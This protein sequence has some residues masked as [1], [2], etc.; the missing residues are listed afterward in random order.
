MVERW[1][2]FTALS[3]DGSSMVY[4]DTVG[5]ASGWQLWIRER[6][7]PD[8]RRLP[9]TTNAGDVVFSPDGQSIVF[10]VGPDLYR[11]HIQGGVSELLFQGT[12]GYSVAMGWMADGSILVEHGAGYL[13]R[14][15]PDPASPVDTVIRFQ[16]EDPDWLYGL[17]GGEAALVVM[18]R[19]ALCTRGNYVG[20]LDL[21]AGSLKPLLDGVLRAWYVDTG[22]VV[23]VNR[24]GSVFATPFDLNGLDFSGEHIPLFEGVQASYFHAD[25]ALGKDGTVLFVKG[26]SAPIQRGEVVWVDRTG[27]VEPVDPAWG[28]AGFNT[29]ALS[30]DGTR[31]AISVAEESGT[32]IHVKDLP[33][34][35]SSP[36]TADRGTSWRPSWTPDGDSIV[37]ATDDSGPY[38]IRKVPSDG[39]SMGAYQVVLQLDRRVPH[40][41][42]TPNGRTLVFRVGSVTGGT[43]DIGL[44]DRATG[45]VNETLKATDFNEMGMAISPDERWLAYVSDATGPREVFVLSFPDVEADFEKVSRNGGTEPV[46]GPEGQNELFYRD[47]NGWMMAA[48]YSTDPVFTVESLDTLF[49]A[50]P[51][52]DNAPSRA[53]DIGPDGERF[54]MIRM[55]E[56]DPGGTEGGERRMVKIRNLF[57]LIEER[58]RGGG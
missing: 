16:G 5:L 10:H 23:W 19:A 54:L 49:D 27:A 34:G 13:A 8:G 40:A 31:L 1:S 25:M 28:M 53:Y 38:E 33:D 43:A 9:G 20:V 12:Q 11:Q 7:S 36:L 15:P 37:Y 52:A 30:P 51:F 57:T 41:V 32:E 17:P 50:R 47:A 44:M 55:E 18:C 14:V 24:E 6:G 22:H 29:P 42:I 46:W 35:N 26:P 39:S 4:R 48:T 56:P 58:A 2:T 3:P 45:E 21:E